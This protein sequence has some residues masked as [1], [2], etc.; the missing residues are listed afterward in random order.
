M[1]GEPVDRH[2][3]VM[4]CTVTGC[5]RWMPPHGARDRHYDDIAECYWYEAKGD[6]HW[7]RVEKACQTTRLVAKLLAATY[8]V[9]PSM[10]SRSQ[11]PAQFASYARFRLA[12]CMHGGL[13]L[14]LQDQSRNSPSCGFT[15]LPLRLPHPA[16]AVSPTATS[17]QCFRFPGLPLGANALPLSCRRSCS[18]AGETDLRQHAW[19]SRR[20]PPRVRSAATRTYGCPP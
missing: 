8:L 19:L 15:M 13:S 16:T 5:T 4:R 7:F 12:D 20:R 9:R 17:P 11:L 3:T 10:A 18:L 6:A 14:Q 1:A 2:Q